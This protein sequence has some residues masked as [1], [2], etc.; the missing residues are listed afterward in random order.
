LDLARLPLNESII[1][2]RHA[3]YN[4]LLAFASIKWQF[5]L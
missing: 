4:A 3:S 1:S 2:V 5:V